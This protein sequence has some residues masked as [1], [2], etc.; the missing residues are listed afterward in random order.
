M[1]YT[2]MLRTHRDSGADIT[3]AVV[4]VRRAQA[5]HLG[6]VQ[7]DRNNRLIQLV[8]KPRAEEQLESLR[9]A[10]G[11]EKEYLAN[12]GVYLCKRQVLLELLRA[13]PEAVD[14][15]T[16]HFARI[17]LSH[18]IQAHL[19]DGY[20]QDL[21]SIRNYHEANL[22]LAS[23][24]PIFDFHDPEGVIYTRM[25]NLPAS[26]V[27]AGHMHACLISD[28]CVIESGSRLERCVVGQRTHIGAN[29]I[30][31]D[32]VISGADRYESDAERAYRR[33]LG[34][35]PIGIG[36][37]SVI[38]RAILDKDCRIGT[39]VRIVNQRQV[40]EAEGDN[41][42]IR[43]GIVVIPKGAVVADGTVI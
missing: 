34:V 18:H 14:L 7:L 24:E 1:K 15:V 43:D 42:V 8:E 6:I 12:M 41:H 13:Q 17:L 31:R 25:R 19:F 27:R 37:G 29:V 39:N 36:A 32:T 9:V 22:G 4:R 38:E 35:P 26:Q 40:R 5:S 28:G 20:W 11:S 30:L 16:Q 23:S 21:G 33:E 10:N 2:D 3:M